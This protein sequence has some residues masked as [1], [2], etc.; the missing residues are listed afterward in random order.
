MILPRLAPKAILTA[1]SLCFMALRASSRFATFTQAISKT[2]P[3][4]ASNINSAGLNV[5]IW[6]S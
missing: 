5:N 6:F 2:K 3:V 4:A 1:V